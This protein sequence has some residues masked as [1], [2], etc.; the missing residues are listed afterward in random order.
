MERKRNLGSILLATTSFVGG[1]AAG[2][3]L[4]PKNGPENRRW[5]ASQASEFSKWMDYQTRAA[6]L[7]TDR[8]L[9]RFRQNVQ[10]G[11]RQNVP[12]LYQA[13]DQIDLG[14]KDILGE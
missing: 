9:R 8:E 12:D 13:T 6:Q 2:F 14:H 3:L 4:A 5:L 11:I 1:L 10:Q 7:K